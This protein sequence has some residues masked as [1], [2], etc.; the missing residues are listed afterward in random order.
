M[1]VSVYEHACVCARARVFVYMC[2]ACVCMCACACVWYVRA[3]VN[4]CDECAHFK[5]SGHYKR[6]PFLEKN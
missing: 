3:C 5:N 1:S 4:G 6:I 2:G